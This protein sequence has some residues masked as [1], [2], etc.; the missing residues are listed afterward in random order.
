MRLGSAR[1]PGLPPVPLCTRVGAAHTSVARDTVEFAV[2]C[3]CA[4]SS[5][6]LPR[7]VVWWD[8]ALA[9]ISLH[10]SVSVV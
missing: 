2:F 9:C 8:G 4:V 6:C 10:A 7:V 1:V 5:K 3:V